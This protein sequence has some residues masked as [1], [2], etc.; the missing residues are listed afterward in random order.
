MDKFELQRR[1]GSGSYAAV[2]RGKRRADG[3]IVAIKQLLEEVP[4]WDATKALPEVAHL[5][6]LRSHP[7]VIRLYEVVRVRT[8]VF[9]VFENCDGSLYDVM[10][11]RLTTAAKFSEEEIRWVIRQIL[12]GLAYCHGKGVMH[13]DLKPENIL[14]SNE[15]REAKLCDFGQVRTVTRTQAHTIHSHTPLSVPRPSL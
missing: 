12:A 14:V 3:R 11:H 10:Q 6:K 2:W 15:A 9:L 4:T 7:N 13:R 8:E 5:S 1:I